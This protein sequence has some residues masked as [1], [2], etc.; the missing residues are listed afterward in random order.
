MREGKFSRPKLFHYDYNVKKRWFVAF[1]YVD[2]E[3]DTIKQ[4]QFRGE[5]NKQ[6]KKKDR[7]AEGNA[8]RDAI[9]QMLLDGWNPATGFKTKEIEL[10][11]SGTLIETINYFVEIRKSSL[12]KESTRTYVDV[13]KV[14]ES[15]LKKDGL[16]NIK[17]H[18]FTNNL[19]RKYLDSRL[20]VGYGAS[21]YNKHQGILMTFFNLM[22]ERKI[23]K[24]NPFKGIKKLRRDIGKNIAFTN[25]E[26][27]K[28][29]AKIKAENPNLYLFVQL[30]FYC[31][32]RRTEIL[33]LKIQDINIEQ[34]TIMVSFGSGKN[35]KQDAVSIPKSFVKELVSINISQYDSNFF[36]FSKNFKPGP[37]K[38]L[39]ADHVTTI[40]K[41]F[42]QELKI[43]ESKTLYSWKHSGVVA[44]YNEILD[45]YALM[46][47]L[48][49]HDLTTTMIYLK[50]LGLASNTPVLNADISI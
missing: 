8:L 26:R 19:A 44:L 29:A 27:E 3:T 28:L 36:L 49:H 5:I 15:W 48:R 12:K 41:K 10:I 31:F 18:Q 22:L 9:Y 23:I 16:K 25:K 32:L 50:S 33:S 34:R 4:F 43:H 39:K 47:Q 6:L 2:E 37:T 20:E 46:R 35:R 11:D 38:R 1:R 24:E 45:P 17:P 30:M 7:I 42:L 40:H 14:F 13:Q 21:T